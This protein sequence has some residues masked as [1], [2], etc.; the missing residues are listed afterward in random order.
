ME[1]EGKEN[2]HAQKKRERE[3]ERPYPGNQLSLHSGLVIHAAM[4]HVPCAS[5][6]HLTSSFAVPV[7]SPALPTPI[8]PTLFPN[9]DFIAFLFLSPA[10]IIV[11]RHFLDSLLV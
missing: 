2:R 8:L 1:K 5:P 10:A 9:V 4:P 6:L 11:E 7:N 3:R